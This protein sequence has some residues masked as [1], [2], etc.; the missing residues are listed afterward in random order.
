MIAGNH[1]P[2]QDLFYTWFEWLGLYFS[3]I[4]NS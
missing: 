3:L 4:R 2:F 1:L